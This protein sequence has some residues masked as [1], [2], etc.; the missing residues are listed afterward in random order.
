MNNDVIAYKGF[1][2]DFRCLGMQYEVGKTFA[3]GGTIVLCKHGLHACERPIDVLSYYPAAGSRFA[4]VNMHGDVHRVQDADSKLA[5]ASLTVVSELGLSDIVE[6][7][8][9]LTRAR[10]SPDA[11]VHSTG[12]YCVSSSVG[13]GIEASSTGYYSMS[14]STGEGSVSSSTGGGSVSSSTGDNSV[15]SSE[16][17]YSV[18]SSTGGRSASSSTGNRSA[19]SSTGY[20]SVSRS[21]GYYSVSSSTGDNS[22]SSSVGEGS[23]SSSTGGRSVSSSTGDNSVSSSTG[24][25]SLAEALGPNSVA[26]SAGRSGR[27]RAKEGSAIMCCYRSK[28]GELIHIRAGIAG[29]DGIKPGVWYELNEH[30][31]FVESI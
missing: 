27:A 12:D 25:Y 2:S 21:A 5:A 14:S 10:C 18:S 30:G 13:S 16:G 28:T 11:T 26:V 8:I 20:G 19:A 4:V 17:Y 7:T 22:V 6:R 31:A 23:V 9:K 1:D 29:R 15:S 24:I 3:V